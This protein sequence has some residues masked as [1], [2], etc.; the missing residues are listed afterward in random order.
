MDISGWF[1]GGAAAREVARRVNH[2]CADVGFL[3]LAGHGIPDRV[4]QGVFSAANRFFSLPVDRKMQLDFALTG[5]H[6]G[7]VPPAVE[8]TDPTTEG[9][10]KEAFNMGLVIDPGTAPP[11]VAAHMGAPNLWPVDLPGFREQVTE[12]FDAVLKLSHVIFDIFAV[13]LG[14]SP[15]QFAEDLKSPIAHMRLL[16][17]PPK[18]ADS[19]R[20]GIGAHCD[21]EMLT[22]LAQD[23][24]GGLE[25]R[26]EDGEW[27]PAPPVP[28]TFVVNIGELL[29]RW[30]NGIYTATPHRVINTASTARCSVPFFFASGYQSV[31]TPL[32][33]CV[34]AE[35]PAGFPPVYAGSYLLQ[36]LHENYG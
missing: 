1:T 23:G 4:T 3:Y 33:T 19:P 5:R 32:D 29:A 18:T 35:R 10:C 31:I 30:T 13:G 16:R 27:I 9:D 36:R 25:V 34:S 17:Y 14:L 7:Y 2:T 24:V 12:Y 15:G 28:G 22:I 20:I 8:A 6:R 11:A 21:Y 26:N